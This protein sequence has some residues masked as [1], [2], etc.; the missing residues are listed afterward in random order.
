MEYE[1]SFL[2]GSVDIT[3]VVIDTGREQVAAAFQQIL[4]SILGLLVTQVGTHKGGGWEALSHDFLL[5][6]NHV[7][8]VTLFLRRPKPS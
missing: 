8:L 7:L 1:Y 3:P 4:D 5:V 6:S 2:H